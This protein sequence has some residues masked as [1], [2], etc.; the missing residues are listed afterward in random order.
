MQ[1]TEEPGQTARVHSIW[2]LALEKQPVVPAAPDAETFVA[3]RRLHVA[4]SSLTHPSGRLQMPLRE[5]TQAE[6]LGLTGKL[7]IV[8]G[9]PGAPPLRY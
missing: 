3:P 6:F 4:D 8:V 7:R 9:I 2:K 1:R 5:Y